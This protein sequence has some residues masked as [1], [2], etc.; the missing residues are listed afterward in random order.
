MK[1]FQAPT[2]TPVKYYYRNKTGYLEWAVTL[3]L[4]SS[5][6]LSVWN[7]VHLACSWSLPYSKINY[8]PLVVTQMPNMVVCSLQLSIS[9]WHLTMPG[10]WMPSIIIMSFNMRL[11]WSVFFLI[12]VILMLHTCNVH[13]SYSW[14]ISD[15]L[16]KSIYNCI[17][18]SIL[19]I[20]WT[21]ETIF[22]NNNNHLMDEIIF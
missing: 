7:L 1:N 18:S 17:Q 2:S 6:S 5:S 15:L 13:V 8:W 14:R 4:A 3:R 12:P 10:E 9:F 20:L 16:Q 19:F 21:G 11:W 22:I